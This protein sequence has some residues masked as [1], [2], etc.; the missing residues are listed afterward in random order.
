MGDLWQY[1]YSVR[2]VLPGEILNFTSPFKIQDS[3]FNIQNNIEGS[4]SFPGHELGV[5]ERY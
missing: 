2:A 1:E 3:R 5:K 4:L